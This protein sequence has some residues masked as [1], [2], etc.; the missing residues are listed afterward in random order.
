M[1]L[2]NWKYY[3]TRTDHSQQPCTYWPNHSRL[4]NEMGNILVLLALA[5]NHKLVP[6]YKRNNCIVIKKITSTLLI[7]AV[8]SALPAA[9]IVKIF[10]SQQNIITWA[11]TFW[12][13]EWE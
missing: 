6:R 3:H 13:S 2:R 9:A 11:Q 1:A 4:T 7:G 8:C 5:N 12:N 10:F